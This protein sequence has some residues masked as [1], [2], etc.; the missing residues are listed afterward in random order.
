MSKITDTVGSIFFISRDGYNLQKIY[1]ILSNEPIKNHYI[2]AP[3]FF[4]II[5]GRDLPESK[6]GARYVFERFSDT[7]EVKAIEMPDN[8]SD[9]DYFIRLNENSDL[10]RSLLERE[11]SRYMKYLEDKVGEGDILLVD[12][13]TRRHSSQRFIQDAV[14]PERRVSGCYYNLMA[15]GDMD[16]SAYADRSRSRISWNEVNVSEFFLGS[17]EP[18]ADD[19]ADDGTP[20]FQ[21]NIDEPELFRM[22]IYDRITR[23]ERDYAEDMKAMFGDEMPK[24]GHKVLDRW[25]KVLVGDRSSADPEHLRSTHST[26]E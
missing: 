11:N 24:I 13:T 9:K 6:D 4:T 19:I 5:F 8:P 7:E 2:Y 18:P 15:H 22:S 20:V 12:V 14:G 3:R 23:G 10:F 1:N 26:C 21:N 17:P 16:Y 25:I